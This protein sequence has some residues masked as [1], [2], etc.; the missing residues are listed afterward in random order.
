MGILSR[1]ESVVQYLSLKRRFIRLNLHA[2]VSLLVHLLSSCWCRVLVRSVGGMTTW[3]V[4]FVSRGVGSRHFGRNLGCH[5]SFLG[6]KWNITARPILRSS[7]LDTS[8][9]TKNLLISVV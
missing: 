7:I 4:V 3:D 9:L 1:T 2:V 6:F 8:I 5:V